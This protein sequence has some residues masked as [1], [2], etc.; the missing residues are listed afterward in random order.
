MLLSTTQLAEK[1]GLAKNTVLR[2]ANGGKIPSFKL[3]NARGDYRFD[4]DEV[5]ATLR[6]NV[7]GE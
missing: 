4:L 1:L 2:M 7:K 3:D 6:K 5:K